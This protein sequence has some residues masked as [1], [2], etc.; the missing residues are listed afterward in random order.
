MDSR[1]E[2]YN[3]LINR[4]DYLEKRVKELSEKKENG[5]LSITGNSFLKRFISELN[6]LN[7]TNQKY[8]RLFAITENN[9][10]VTCLSDIFHY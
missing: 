4:I 3:A 10:I 1:K 8:H 6:V 2:F 5:T 9:N 7:D